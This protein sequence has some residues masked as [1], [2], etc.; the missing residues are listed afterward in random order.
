M[1]RFR[2]FLRESDEKATHYLE[3]LQGHPHA[4]FVKDYLSQNAHTRS[5]YLGF[6]ANPNRADHR[7]PN[8]VGNA[9]DYFHNAKGRLGLAKDI[10]AY[11]THSAL[12][13]ATEQ[14][15]LA[16]IS[17][18][19]SGFS[20]PDSSVVHNQNGV[21]IST[22]PT[23]DSA[24]ATRDSQHT[25]LKSLRDNSWCV[26]QPLDHDEAAF[27]LAHRGHEDPDED[28]YN[29][30]SHDEADD[31]ARIDHAYNSYGNH[32]LIQHRDPNT[33]AVRSSMYASPRDDDNRI[34]NDYELNDE[35]QKGVGDGS[36]L[37]DSVRSE[38]YRNGPKGIKGDLR[39]AGDADMDEY[40]H[41]LPSPRHM[42]HSGVLLNIARS[43]S[44]RA[45]AATR[46]L[47]QKGVLNPD[48]NESGFYQSELFRNPRAREALISS[49]GS[50]NLHEL[51]TSTQA[52]HTSVAHQL[53]DNLTRGKTLLPGNQAHVAYA[54]EPEHAHSLPF[55][56]PMNRDLV[57]KLIDT[58]GD[59]LDPQIAKS[60][61]LHASSHAKSFPETAAD[62]EDI[63]SHLDK[64]GPKIWHGR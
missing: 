53:L 9:V 54:T 48:S 41:S 11:P 23:L 45:G 1:I 8:A 42:E 50:E 37:P 36:H 10:N 15:R 46:T 17:D 39:H 58:H 44:T 34:S 24:L 31:L 56:R 27:Q 26:T 4:Q 40:V 52:M 32:H 16:P 13:D 61:R 63:I 35:S 43:N 22:L 12:R 55:Q 59:K 29:G 33:G 6:V 49:I 28:D 60:V 14:H 47:A 64:Y 2:R 57:K 30:W 25:K 18:R 51:P 20:H 38:L 62:H 5:K 21:R 3:R 19:E 7:D